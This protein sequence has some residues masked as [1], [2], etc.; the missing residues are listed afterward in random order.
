MKLEGIGS[1]AGYLYISNA[2]MKAQNSVSHRECLAELVIARDQNTKAGLIHLTY[3]KIS[4]WI[5]LTENKFLRNYYQVDHVP[6]S[7]FKTH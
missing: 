5:F 1:G 6:S 4:S 2:E 3:N 7:S